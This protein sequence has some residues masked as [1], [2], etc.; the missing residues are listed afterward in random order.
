VPLVRTLRLR[1]R[2]AG[3]GDGD[4]C[5]SWS[6]SDATQFAQVGLNALPADDPGFIA[7]Q[8]ERQWLSHGS[9]HCAKEYRIY[10]IEAH[11]E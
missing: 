3:R 9:K 4:G 11:V 1:P 5:T 8:T 2:G 10:C 6:S 7:W